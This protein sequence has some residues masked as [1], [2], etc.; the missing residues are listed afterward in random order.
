MLLGVYLSYI[1]IASIITL[2]S[3][4]K[5]TRTNLIIGL[6]FLPTFECFFFI[7]CWI[8]NNLQPANKTISQEAANGVFLVPHSSQSINYYKLKSIVFLR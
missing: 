3:A 6:L 8:T 2:T 1:H 4:F 5:V 7:F